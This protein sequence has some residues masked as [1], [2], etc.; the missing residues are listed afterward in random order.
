M[1]FKHLAFAAATVAIAAA[2]LTALADPWWGGGD[3]HDNWR[4][5]R[6]WER[7]DWRAHEWREHEWREHRRWGGDWGYGWGRCHWETQGHYS[8]WGVYE[9]RQV[10]VCD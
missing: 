9:Y 7:Q 1:S 10:R 8:P 3:R 6:G 4:A 2:P 5:D